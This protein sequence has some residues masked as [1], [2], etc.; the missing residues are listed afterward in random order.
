M[1]ALPLPLPAMEVLGEA[2]ALL[3]RLTCG[4]LGVGEGDDVALAEAEG[5]GESV[6]RADA[7]G[8]LAV[9]SRVGNGELEG[10]REAAAA[11]VAAEEAEGQG[12]V[13]GADGEAV[14]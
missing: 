8:A 14:P 5:V 6:A 3:L 1:A 9:A 13:L 7:L 11:P 4:A 2:E 12:V 10:P